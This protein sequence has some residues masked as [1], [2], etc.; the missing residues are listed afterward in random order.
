MNTPPTRVVHVG[1]S[2]AGD[3][4][5]AHNGDATGSIK[6]MSPASPAVTDF[7][8]L[9]AIRYGIAIWTAPKSISI[10]NCE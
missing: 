5:Y 8:P 3:T 2:V 1:V 10:A 6:V 9:A 4:I 7:R